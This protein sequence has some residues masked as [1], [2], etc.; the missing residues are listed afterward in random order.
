MGIRLQGMDTCN[1]IWLT[2]CAL[3]NWLLEVD[4]LDGEWEGAIGQLE[5]EDVIWHVPFAMKHL[6]LGY[7]PREYDESGLDPGE[8]RDGHEVVMPM[9][10][11]DDRPV[12]DAESE[13]ESESESELVSEEN[14]VQVVRHL[15]LKYFRCKLIEHFDI[16]FK[17]HELVWPTHR[18]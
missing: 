7:D 10:Y 18:K 6:A 4:G 3:H 17:H 13:S 16:L 14:G 11:G 8:D 2:C 9:V 15:S 5:A 1:N 12:T